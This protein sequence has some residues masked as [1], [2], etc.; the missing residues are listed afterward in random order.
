MLLQALRWRLTRTQRGPQ[1]DSV[2]QSYCTSDLLGLGLPNVSALLCP[3]RPCPA[4]HSAFPC[5]LPCHAMLC[6]TLPYPALCLSLHPTLPCYATVA[7][8]LLLAVSALPQASASDATD[9]LNDART[10]AQ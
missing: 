9:Q 10:L 1:R 6:P 8:S 7:P 3:A 5:T 4:L 2:M